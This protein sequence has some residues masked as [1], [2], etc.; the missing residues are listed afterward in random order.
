MKSG[1]SIVLDISSDGNFAWD[2]VDRE[3][4]ERKDRFKSR[5]EREFQRQ[6][7]ELKA[8]QPSSPQAS[9]P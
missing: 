6:L 4:K 7:R 8:T 3:T 9:L 5:R 2:V 1:Y